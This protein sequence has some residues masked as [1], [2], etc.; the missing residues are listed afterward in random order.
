M[1]IAPI[2]LQKKKKINFRKF[3]WF[4][5]EYNEISVTFVRLIHSG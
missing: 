1:L 5:Y 3:N 2:L 4:K